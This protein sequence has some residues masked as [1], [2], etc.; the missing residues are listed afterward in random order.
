MASP[1]AAQAESPQPWPSPVYS[2]DTDLVALCLQGFCPPGAPLRIAPWAR[3]DPSKDSSWHSAHPISHPDFPTT[4]LWLLSSA[5]LS[6][7]LSCSSHP[8]PEAEPR[9]PPQEASSQGHAGQGWVVILG[10]GRGGYFVGRLWFI[11]WR[12]SLSPPPS[13][14]SGLQQEP[15]LA[16]V[17]PSWQLWGTYVKAMFQM[18]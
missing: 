17:A 14:V 15:G 13:F 7:L 18:S 3:G 16:A 4:G 6:P 9:A 8:D 5:K 2:A 1:L 10:F 11:I 12:P